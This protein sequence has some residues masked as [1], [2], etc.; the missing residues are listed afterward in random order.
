MF[1]PKC[2]LQN[3]SDARFCQNCG[4]AINQ[5]VSGNFSPPPPPVMNQPGGMANSQPPR[6]VGVNMGQYPNGGY[7]NHGQGQGQVEYAHIGRRFIASLID[8]IMLSVMISGIS[9]AIGFIVVPK[10][11]ATMEMMMLF[12][13]VLQFALG[14]FYFSH[15]ESSVHGATF[16]KQLMGIKVTDLDGNRISFMTGVKRYLAK[17]PSAMILLI[18]FIM[19]AF[20]DKRQALHDKLAGCLVV[21]K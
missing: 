4:T 5:E 15:M 10:T 11:K 6:S 12:L 19:A 14:L 2:G 1:C 7:V 8:G 18:G 17:I 20:T 9:A 3:V 21:R 16:G 13:N